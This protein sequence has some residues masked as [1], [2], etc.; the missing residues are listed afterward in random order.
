MTFVIT[1]VDYDPTFDEA[2]FEVNSIINTKPN[3]DN[4]ND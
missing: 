3:A 2:Y 1:S 4:Q